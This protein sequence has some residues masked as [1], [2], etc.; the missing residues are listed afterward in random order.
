MCSGLAG[1]AGHGKRR[2]LQLLVE[3]G[4][5]EG[6]EVMAG[7]PATPGDLQVAR[8]IGID[9]FAATIAEDK[10]TPAPPAPVR[11]TERPPAAVTAS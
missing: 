11:T 6:I 7:E 8:E 3:I 1:D 5:S 9:C 4:R 10:A 2:L